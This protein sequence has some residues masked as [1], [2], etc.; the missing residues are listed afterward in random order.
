MADVKVRG[1]CCG[2]PFGFGILTVLAAVITFAGPLLPEVS[3]TSAL[4]A[5]GK[6]L[7]ISGL[8]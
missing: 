3:S 8:L 5:L 1:C 2:I 6:L 7:A 4:L